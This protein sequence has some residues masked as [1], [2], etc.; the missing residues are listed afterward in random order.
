[1]SRTVKP[2]KTETKKSDKNGF[3]R[4]VIAKCSILALQ[5][6]QLD[7]LY[8]LSKIHPQ[9]VDVFLINSTK[10]CQL[11]FKVSVFCGL[12]VQFI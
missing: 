5:N 8:Y 2:Q 9:S 3:Y 1:M 4:Q 7:F 6:A 10:S 11:L 12:T